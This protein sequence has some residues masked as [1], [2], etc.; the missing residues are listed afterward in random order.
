[1]EVQN[2]MIQISIF[3]LSFGMKPQC[4]NASFEV[5]LF[6]LVLQVRSFKQAI[7]LKIDPSVN[8]DAVH[9]IVQKFGEVKVKHV[10]CA[11]FLVNFNF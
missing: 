2:D 10:L 8:F 5:L 3:I 11:Q 9:L 7:V 4:I 1:M 6:D